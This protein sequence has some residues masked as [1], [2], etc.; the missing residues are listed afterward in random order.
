MSN[1]SRQDATPI[2]FSTI[3]L[4]V[5][6]LIIL[7]I[8]LLYEQPGLVL[9]C[10][11]LLVMFG[12]ARLWCSYSLN[13]ISC[14]L[15]PTRDRAFPGEEL[16]LKAETV[17]NKLLP[18]WLELAVFVDHNLLSP[19]PE[20]TPPVFNTAAQPVYT[21]PLQKKILFGEGGL[22][23]KIKASLDW[24]LKAQRR[25]VFETGPIR[26]TVGDLFGFYRQEK[27]LPQTQTIIVYPRL[28]ALN[29]FSLPL[30]ELFGTP[31]S[32]SPVVDPVYQIAT[33]DYQEGGPARHIHWKASARLGR[34]QEKV[35]EPSV[36]QKILLVV[37]VDR[38]YKEQAEKSFERMLKV[39]ASLAVQLARQGRIFGMVSNGLLTGINS[40]IDAAILPPVKK[41]SQLTCLLEILAR[42]QMQTGQTQTL[43]LLQA[44]GLSRGITCL[45]FTYD[46]TRID[47]GVETLFSRFKIP[48]IAVAVKIPAN[49]GSGI[50]HMEE[51]IQDGV[52]TG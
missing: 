48:L 33:R 26:L 43:D 41:A 52:M 24:P 35:F 30:R 10:L 25:G 18:V 16:I 8:A 9:L 47:A 45:Y 23:W 20:E 50:Y 27:F 39:A 11:L 13:G 29:T 37:D 31:G 32:K 1:H 49:G 7:F 46:H 21:A 12:C 19:A 5:F 38:F 42:L 28:I 2:L 4:Q 3:P 40:V 17:N 34:L 15:K 6:I 14:S 22:L 36:Q 44:A 51:L